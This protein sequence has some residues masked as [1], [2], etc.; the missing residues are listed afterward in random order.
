MCLIKTHRFPKISRKP[1]KCYKR[2][3]YLGDDKYETLF[4]DYPFKLGD[5]IK[6]ARHWIFGIFKDSLEGE[7]VHSY[8]IGGIS[9]GWIECEIP[10][11]TP[12]WV[13]H[14]DDIGAAK[15]KTIRRII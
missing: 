2:V 5:I 4:M 6:S 8:N 15:I 9:N 3:T 7:V 11:F 13:G 12:Y 14:C 10:P 1:I